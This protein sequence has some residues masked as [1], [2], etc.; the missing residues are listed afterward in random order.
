MP[1]ASRSRRTRCRRTIEPC[2]CDAFIT[3]GSIPAAFLLPAWLLVGWAV[4]RAGGWAFLWVLFLAIPAVFIGQ[5]VLTMLVRAR[6]T[7]RAQ[8]AVSWWDVLGF[9][10][11]HMLVIS[12]G[13]FEQSWWAPAMVATIFVGIGLLWLTLWQLWR[14]AKP[15][16]MVMYTAEGVA[17]LPPDDTTSTPS[18]RR[19]TSTAADG[20]VF[21]ITEKRESDGR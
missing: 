18:A 6:G 19:S 7:V 1:A 11:W 2:G 17:Y 9:T 13:F 4:F 16:R 10:A 20:E 14:E 21:V 12:L 3:P 15:G 8:R 5:L